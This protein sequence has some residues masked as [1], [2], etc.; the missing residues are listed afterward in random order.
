M[1]DKIRRNSDDQEFLEFAKKK[2][3]EIRI[4]NE[5]ESVDDAIEQMA[6][7][8]FVPDLMP[9]VGEKYETGVF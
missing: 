5:S 7:S 6:Q 4:V 8:G 2:A 1:D 9:I 3:K